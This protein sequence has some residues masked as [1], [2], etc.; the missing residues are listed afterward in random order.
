[1]NNKPEHEIRLGAIKAAI[2]NNSTSNAVRYNVTLS[3]LFKEGNEWRHTESFGRD[4]L[5]LVAKVANLAH[6]WIFDQT[7]GARNSDKTDGR[8]NGVTN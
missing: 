3:R 4:D 6:S 5:L 2:W 7:T 8:L 1:M